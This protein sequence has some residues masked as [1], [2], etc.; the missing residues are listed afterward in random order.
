MRRLLAG[1]LLALLL[2]PAPLRAVAAETPSFSVALSAC[3]GR[4]GSA[5]DLTLDYSGG[6]GPV[7]AFAFWVSFDPDV[8]TCQPVRLAGGLRENYTTAVTLEEGKAA[9]AYTQKS[10]A[11]AYRGPGTALTYR[12]SVREDAPEGP[13]GIQVRLG[14]VLS[15]LGDELRPDM[16][17]LLPYEVLAPVSR[18][19]SLYSLTPDQGQLDQ[20]FS[21]DQLFYTMSVPYSVKSLTF[22]AVPAQGATCRVNRKNLG[23]GGSDTEFK[24]TVTAADGKTQ[25]VY[26]VNVHR[27]EK[28][29][30]SGDASLQGLVPDVGQLDQVFLP[31]RLAYTMSVPYGTK[32]LHFT[33]TPAEGAVCRVNRKTLEAAGSETGFQITV[34]AADGKTRQVYRVDVYRE[35]PDALESDASLLDLR[36]DAGAFEQDFSA[37]RLHYT[38]RVPYSTTAVTFTA[39]P[40]QGASFRVDRKNLGAG[41]STTG[42]AITVTAA[43]GKT[44][45]VYQVDVYREEKES[46]SG[47][48]SLLVL[49][50]DTGSLDQAFSPGQLE[51][52]MSVPF[53]VKSLTFQ[54]EPAPG[55][56]CRVN[57]KNLGAGGSDTE[58]IFTVTAADGKTKQTYRV[59]VH[60]G[61]EVQGST[62][63]KAGNGAAAV[64]TPGPE[65]SPAA[66]PSPKPSPSPRTS[67]SPKPS[68]SPVA[69]GVPVPVEVESGAL[70][71]ADAPPLE[72]P[73]EELPPGKEASREE[74]WVYGVSAAVLGAAALLSGPAAKWLGKWQALRESKS[75]RPDHKER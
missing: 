58:F 50:P 19:A 12:F 3:E 39:V 28:E 70:G 33:A 46:A 27:E 32:E 48:A 55:A 68:S 6:Q 7:G 72:L 67:S 42:F 64:K 10:T 29:A 17:R 71:E 45:Q 11:L 21:P 4:G 14:Q 49:A 54:T 1:L 56:T 66:S 38:M 23:A 36:P 41:G 60:R 43:D 61:Q 31:E 57:R 9:V 30:L 53:S 8:F 52:T 24:I 51:Y 65:K 22:T 34:T 63:S 69:G 2:M 75:D 26:V 44:K 25:Q 62:S 13:C 59:M 74:T 73:V 15:P 20:D 37:E 18:E 47:D 35:L 40:A 5:F 16:E